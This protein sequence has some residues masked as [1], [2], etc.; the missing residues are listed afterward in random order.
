MSNEYKEWL[1]EQSFES[2]ANDNLRIKLELKT[3]KEENERLKEDKITKDDLRRE[4][5][6][7][8][9]VVERLKEEMELA[10]L[11]VQSCNVDCEI[12]QLREEND[13]LTQ[14]NKQMKEALKRILNNKPDLNYCGCG[15]VIDFIDNIAK[16][17]L[18]ELNNEK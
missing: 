4:L 11:C 18:K 17:S 6:Y 13:T 2:L 14:Q 12:K 8:C 15:D 7:Q 9:E 10:P 3:A 5:N 1:K 16:Q